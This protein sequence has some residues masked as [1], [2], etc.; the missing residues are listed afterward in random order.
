MNKY[1]RFKVGDTVS[2]VSQS[3]GTYLAKVGTV[4]A[5]VPAGQSPFNLA[6]RARKA[7]RPV[8]MT[9]ITYGR[10]GWERDHVSF[11]VN[12]DGKA[13]WPRVAALQS[14]TAV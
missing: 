5:I 10:R 12:V 8:N 3:H 13:Y 2:W 9:N 4:A 1:R 7:Y 6:R 11:V 14:A